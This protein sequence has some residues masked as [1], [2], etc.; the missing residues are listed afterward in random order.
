MSNELIT[1]QPGSALTVLT[2]SDQ[3]DKLISEVKEKV[4]NLDGGNMQT[5]VGRKAI[6][7]NANKAKKSKTALNKIIDDLIQQ[8]KDSIE[9]KTKTE[10][11]VIEQLKENK[12][13]LGSGLDGIYKDARQD[14]TDFENE[15]KRIKEEEEAIKAAHELKIQREADHEIALIL[16]DKFDMEAEKAAK[17]KEQ[18]EAEQRAQMQREA[19]EKAKADAEKLTREAEDRAK[20]AE[21]D[22]IAAEE[23]AKIDAE[24]AE[25][26]R[27]ADVE[28]A[29]KAEQQRIADEAAKKEAEEAKRKL[30]EEHYKK[31]MLETNQYFLDMGISQEI[32]FKITESLR[33]G[34]VPN[35][36][37][38][39][40]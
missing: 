10:Q 33:D 2:S 22:R 9:E 27:L 4:N 38:M 40:F 14:V 12:S 20:Q 23:K 5:G 32:A 16:N 35:T 19:E 39:T 24:N 15:L 7:T 8:Q 11:R 30:D 26:K 36:P 18:E 29:K 34:L 3:V 21:R 1:I 28:E 37:K 17:E 13:R 25:K 31:V 6:I